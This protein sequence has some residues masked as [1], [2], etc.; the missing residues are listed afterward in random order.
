MSLSTSRALASALLPIALAAPLAAQ[1]WPQW[2][3]PTR[4]GVVAA[5]SVPATWPE[6]LTR[7][8][9]VEVG[10]GYAAPVLVGDRLYVF[11][12][13]GD[14]EV[15]RALDARTGSEI[16]ST[17]YPAP[18]S[19]Q[20]AA[21]PHGPGPKAT[22][23]YADGRLFTLGLGGVVSAFDATTG[24][25]LWHVPEP[26]TAPLYGTAAS[27]V[28]EGNLVIV[29][30]GGQDDGALT[31]Y[32]VATGGVRWSWDGD[33]PSYASPRVV[34]IGGVRQVVT[35]SQDHVIGVSVATGDLLWQRPFTTNFTQNIIDPV[36]V[37]DLVVVSGY[38]EPMSAFRVARGAG[39]WTTTDVWENADASL[40]MTNGVLVDGAL[41]A[42]SQRNSGQFVLIEVETGATR[43][44]GEGRQ[45]ENAAILRAGNV[46]LVLEEDAELVVGRVG[47]GGFEELR[48]YAVADAAT[49]AQP[50]VSG[51]RLFVK[52]VARVTLWTLN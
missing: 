28:V 11:A 2:R 49:W 18:F 44:T 15:M 19:F 16:W 22:P 14:D 35:L 36:V 9:S 23:T 21:E 33:G 1:D 13:Q 30:V 40:Y 41:F 8:W 25:R 37:G 5:P 39:G 45:A 46:L 51:N 38:Q 20:A 4:D 29:N 42:L 6:R 50:A 3:G 10:A 27:P 43:W 17:A 48:R 12:R 34:E 24:D 31:A 32:D 26:E 52:D 7:R 47:G